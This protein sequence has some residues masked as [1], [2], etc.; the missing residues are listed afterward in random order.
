MDCQSGSEKE[1]MDT[2]NKYCEELYDLVGH[3]IHLDTINDEHDKAYGVVKE[4][5][6]VLD[7]LNIRERRRAEELQV[8]I[9]ENVLFNIHSIVTEI[10]SVLPSTLKECSS[11][12][13]VPKK[14]GRPKNET[15]YD[16]A[17]IHNLKACFIE[18]NTYNKVIET[19][20][21]FHN[22]SAIKGGFVFT[23]FTVLQEE[24]LLKSKMKSCSDFAE[25]MRADPQI[26]GMIPFTS[27]QA[28]YSSNKKEN[29]YGFLKKTFG[30]GLE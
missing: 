21:D 2:I 24:S 3:N 10:I 29:Y 23:L 1:A 12:A 27:F 19:I 30:S 7:E 18:E 4:K 9:C 5:W 14:K 22:R 28:L 26:C 11:N 15:R 25:F 16:Q 6:K 20:R 17:G 8:Q 13:S